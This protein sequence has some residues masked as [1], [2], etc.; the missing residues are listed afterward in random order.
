MGVLINC[1]LGKKKSGHFGRIG[2]GIYV[3]SKKYHEMDY[4]YEIC[5]KN[6]N[7]YDEFIQIDS[8][9]IWYLDYLL[10]NPNPD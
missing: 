8:I 9:L 1:P 4:K 3:Q 7:K 6:A 5:L 2:V 10:N